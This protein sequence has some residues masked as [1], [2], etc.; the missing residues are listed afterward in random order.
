MLPEKSPPRGGERVTEEWFPDGE[1]E[2]EPARRARQVCA[3]CPVRAE[4][5]ELALSMPQRP[6]G[7]WGGTTERERRDMRRERRAA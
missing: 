7:I 2:G 6:A 5:L 4:C 3:G 1:G